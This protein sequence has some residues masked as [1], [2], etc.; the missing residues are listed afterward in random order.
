[1]FH[2]QFILDLMCMVIL[3]CWIWKV[4][5]ILLQVSPTLIKKGHNSFVV[6]YS[7]SNFQ[8]TFLFSSLLFFFK[9]NAGQVLLFFTPA[10]SPS[11]LP[12]ITPLASTS[13]LS[14]SGFFFNMSPFVYPSPFLAHT[15]FSVLYSS[16][17]LVHI[18]S[19]SCCC[20]VLWRTDIHQCKARVPHCVCVCVCARVWGRARVRVH[21]CVCVCVCVYV[22]AHTLA[23][24]YLA[25]AWEGWVGCGCGWEAGGGRAA[26]G[27]RIQTYFMH[28][29]WN[30]DIEH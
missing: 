6:R 29:S 12:C 15:R 3:C 21:V 24:T 10:P 22:S 17:V 23:T 16:S 5:Q 8:M 26:E 19:L 20:C 18:V 28:I 7:L 11:P 9:S 30:S 2:W 13:A 27:V 25:M 4:R 14:I 1:M